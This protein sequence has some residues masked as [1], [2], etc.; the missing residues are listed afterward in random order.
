MANFNT[1][2]QWTNKT[3]NI[4]LTANYSRRRSGADMIY[5]VS[6]S[7]S[8]CYGG[9][10][11]G[12]P[13]YA[14]IFVNGEATARFSPTL[15]NA[16][17]SSWTSPISYSTG[18]FTVSN[19]TSGTT[20]LTI[21][22]YSSSAGGRD[23][24]WTFD[25]A[26]DPAYFT[27]KPTISISDITETSVKVNWSTSENCNR[28]RYK[29]DSGSFVEV[30][31][32]NA[33]SGSF[34]L[35]GLSPASS[36]NVLI[37]GRRADSG[38]TTES[39]SK[40]FQLYDYPYCSNSPNFTIGNAL[41]LTFYN[42]LKRNITVSIL[43][44]SNVVLA[45]ATTNGTSITGFNNSGQIAN[46][47]ASIPN[48]SSGIYKV[49]VVYGS[50]TKTRANNNTYTIKYTEKPIVNNL[51]ASYHS[52]YTALTNN[53]QA[54]IN[55]KSTIT[56]RITNGATAQNSSSIAKY[57]VSWGNST[58]VEITNISNSVNLNVG[59][60]SIIN[61]TAYDTRGLNTS[62][63][64]SISELI[65]YVDPTIQASTR[66]NNGIEKN[67]YIT[68]KGKIFYDKFGTNGVSNRV[69]KVEYWV[70][71]SQS[72]SGN[73]YTLYISSTVFKSYLG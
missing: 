39:D 50:S 8:T 35:T 54:V 23:I 52:N 24:T 4:Y 13:I 56:F 16:S 65:N 58:P 32:G 53:D 64:I 20:G 10:Y 67:T 43:S 40:P 70:S 9:N 18:E 34:S 30:F 27:T 49:R 48:N 38:L 19:K 45:T 60:G 37:E 28:I 36:H 62:K 25:M 29:L 3:P 26:V 61:I 47:Y 7:I 63:T 41:T 15:K 5:N 11:F 42:P 17:P 73:P 22:L 21:R 31:T 59:E 46:Y 14:Q 57:L 72:W 51:T 12:Y 1:A 71:T 6:L 55:G 33:T 66:R 69:Q 68:I 2:L 44:N